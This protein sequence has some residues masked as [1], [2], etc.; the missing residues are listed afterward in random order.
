MGSRR[1]ELVG[2]A[3]GRTVLRGHQGPVYGIAFS[4]DGR[5]VATASQD[6]AIRVW[7]ADGSTAFTL[8][9]HPGGART[10]RYSADGRWLVSTGTDETVRIWKATTPTEPIVFES[11]GPPVVSAAFDHDATRV[12]TLHADGTAR[13]WSCDVCGPSPFGTAPTR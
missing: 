5:H 8:P 10:V 6:G 7:N 1:T 13:V 11:F 2:A 3:D 12:A 4:P 9:G